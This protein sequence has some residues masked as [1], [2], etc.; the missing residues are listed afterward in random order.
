MIKKGLPLWA[1]SSFLLVSTA[2]AQGTATYEL[3]FTSTWTSGTHPTNYPSNPHFSGMIGGTHNSSVSFW[4]TGQTA[5]DGIKNMAEF[6]SKGTLRSEINQA[7]ANNNADAIIDGAGLGRPPTSARTTFTIRPPWNLVTV[8]SMLA[9][10]PDWFVGVSGLNLLDEN[11]NWRQRVEVILFVY[12]AGTDSGSDYDSPNQATNPR[13]NI[14]RISTSPFLVNGTVTS[15]GSFVFELK[16]S[17]PQVN[18]SVNK[19]SVEE[20]EAVTVTVE[21]SEALTSNVT[22]PVKLTPGTAE[23]DDYDSTSPVN[24]TITSGQTEADRTINTYEDDD[25]DNESFNVQIDTDNLPPEVVA[26]SPLSAEITITDSDVPEVSLS[27]D[28]NSVEEGEAVTVTVE[29]SEALTSNVTIP[30]N[31]TS[32]TAE[33]GD[34][35]STSPVNVTITGG[36]TEADHTINTYEDDDTK[37]ESFSVAI[38]E[39]NLPAQVMAGSPRSV[40]ITITDPDVPEVSLSVDK[41]SV[42]EGEAVTV[43]V[44]L[45]EAL[46]SNV[47]IPLNLTSGTAESGDYDSTSP[48]NVTITG[49]QTEADHTINT[50]EDDDTKNESFS[51]AIDEDNLPAQV[52]AGSPRSVSITITDPDVP[53][54]S[55]S[56]DKNSVEE[57]ESVTV[58]VELSDD[59]A[60]NVTIPLKLTPGTA[61]ADDYDSTS[62]VS[63]TITSGQTEAEYSINTYED[64]DPDNESFNV[65]IDTDNLPPEVV[66]GSPRSVSI[67]ITDPDVPEVSLSV[68]KNSVEE[69]ESVTVTVELSDDLASNVTIPLKLTPGTAEADDYDSTSPVSV[70]ITS[71]QTEAEYSINTYED[72]DPDNESFN[73]QI[74]TDNLPPEVVAGSP[75]S[76]EITITDSDVPEVSLSVDQNSVEEGEAVTVTVELSEALTSNVTIPLNLTSGT[77]ESGDYDSTSPVNVTITGGQTEADHT[78]NTYEDDDTKN[79]SFSVA[80]DEDNLPAQV[81]AGSP[82][83]VSITITD[84]DVPEVSLSVDKNSAEEGESVTV[85][86]E[87][88]DDLASN[89]TIPLKLTPGTAEADDYDSTSPVSVTITSG[90]TEAKYTINTYEDDDIENESFN[91]Q[92]DTDNLPPEVVAGSP[93]S[94]E[95]TI[96]DSD[97]PEVSLSVDQNS[98]EE[99]EAVTVTVE[100]SEALT[101]NVTIPLNLT[102]GTAESGDYDSTSPVNVTITGGQT[103]ADHTINTYEDDDTKNESFSVAIDEDNLPAQVMAGSPRS[104][105]I[106]ITDPDVPEVS[107]SV[108]KNSVEEGESVTVTVELSDDLASNVTIP[109]NLTPGTAEADDYDSTSPVNIEIIS[110]QTEA[111]YSI[112]TYEDDDIE[113]ESFNVQIDTDNLPPEVV[114]GSPLSVEI[115]I[116]DASMPEV[117]LSVDQNSVVEGQPV[118]VTIELSETLAINVTIP[119]ALTQGTAEADDYDSASPVS[120]DITSGQT[121]AEYTIKTYEDADTENETFMV[122]IDESNLPTGII[123][124]SSTSAEVTIT[125]NDMPEVNLSV[126][127]NSVA[128]GQPVT[129]TIALSETLA[130]N[131]TIPLVLT[132]G[133]AESDDYDST[134]PVNV[135][136]TGGQ[137]EAEYTIKTYE[138]ADTENETFMVAIDEDNLPAGIIL[139]AS[140]SAEVKITD[141]D[142]P[143]ILAPV[144]VEIDEGKSEAVQISLMTQPSSDVTVTI[145]GYENADL[146][147]DQKDL[148]FT[149]DNYNT[150]Q[151][152]TLITTEDSD[153][154]N[155]EVT[156]TLA[157]S[158]GGYDEVSQTLAVTIRDNMGVGIE[159]EAPSISITLWGNYPNPVSDLTKIVFDLPEPAQIS[160]RVTDLLGRIVQTNP[161]GWYEA[162]RDHT[163]E[164]GTDNLTSGVYY[165]TLRV[166]MGDQVIQRSKAMSVVR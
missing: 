116:T 88:S 5:S 156:L 35:D 101:S 40:S 123:L 144:S 64:D 26:G 145:T 146:E 12:D 124:G 66:A 95:I 15:V 161:Y 150:P 83:S 112:N 56:V 79:E 136:I 135:T 20:G 21:L 97:V 107:L 137:T 82:R 122:A 118:T 114:A 121:E 23:A 19:N 132:P 44:E 80:I 57:G 28:Q 126:D 58:T 32:G 134:S 30:L 91:V 152:V 166:D 11:N 10:S 164:I 96:T 73:V 9:P 86:V 45:S 6:G 38:D 60:S 8:T 94:A 18:L 117:S 78:I 67:T 48:V 2:M 31:L 153:L 53:E 27:V 52:M 4:N 24:I 50:Y 140:T 61:E 54:V 157:A 49:G 109:L 1:M 76:A 108:D 43:T 72:D 84:P 147:P 162:G 143:G 39:D 106:T 130:N 149:E 87:L 113:N 69:G 105:S 17:T 163:V 120:V 42:E 127:Q 98:V 141:N 103:E 70:T 92:I 77:A 128:E 133:T 89:V 125:D 104:V 13:E 154:L 90:Q 142:M 100:L 41:N 34:Y 3:T 148:T 46:T 93:L 68:D 160:V 29:L 33:S 138:D 47:T 129:V 22:I 165:Y 51:V 75:L 111:E 37:N 110:G 99:G 151:T 85:T 158:G 36:Q 25:P 55:L 7:K 81:M 119:L 115:T 14:S 59:L 131:T 62:P 71:G 16:S 155:D 63:V 139:G 65:Q 102:S 159:D 74:D